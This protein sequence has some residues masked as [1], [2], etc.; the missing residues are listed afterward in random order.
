MAGAT[1]L[2]QALVDFS[3]SGLF[4]DETVSS[5]KLTSEELPGA[6]QAL[7]E[8]KTKLEARLSKIPYPW[9]RM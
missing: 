2:G 4:P 7:A 3:T 6:I 5:V 8:A 1:S 9:W